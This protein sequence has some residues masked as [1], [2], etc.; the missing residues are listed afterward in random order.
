M[1]QH[2]ALVKA[3]QS[4]GVVIDELSSDGLADSVFIEDTVV[5]VGDTAMITNPG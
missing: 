2:E 3:M 1:E 4:T 5:I